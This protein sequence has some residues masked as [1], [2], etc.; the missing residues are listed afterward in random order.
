MLLAHSAIADSQYKTLF[1][2]PKENKKNTVKTNMIVLDQKTEICKA[3]IRSCQFLL[4]FSLFL[5][6][7]I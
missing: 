3:S 1:K 7:F 5:P 4:Q 2:C 6:P